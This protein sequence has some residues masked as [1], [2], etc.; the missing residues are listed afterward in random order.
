[1]PSIPLSHLQD[2]PHNANVCTTITLEKIRR[3]IE[4]SGFYP[5]LI[6]RPHPDKK[7]QYIILD[8][9]HRKQ[10]LEKLGYAEAECQIWTVDESGAQ[11]ALATLNRLH[12]EDEPRKR[13]ELLQSLT[14]TIPLTELTQLVPESN[15]EIDDLLA[16][17]ILD[18]KEAEA[19]INLQIEQDEET[20]PVP[21]ACMVHKADFPLVEQAFLLVEGMDQGAKLV[22]L[23]QRVLKE[24]GDETH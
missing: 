8:G 2:D 12:G 21:F 22:T 14:Q 18:W 23:C 9:H 5:P 6:V 24:S 20:L 11:L 16:L 4:R 19:K 1:M 17:L 3:N 13:A 10:V 15:Q 7:E